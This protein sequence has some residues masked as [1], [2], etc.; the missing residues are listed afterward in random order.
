[1][2]DISTPELE[3]RVAILEA[4]C[5]DKHYEM[6]REILSH[7]ASTIQSNVRELE[8][9]LNKVI[10]YHQFKNI[11]PSIESV[12]EIISSF[13]ASAGS[14]RNLTPKQLLET[15]AAYFDLSVPDLLGKCR[16]KRL[17]FPRQ[18]IMYLMRE[19]M[20]SSYPAIGKMIGGRDH[21]TAIHAYNKIAADLQ[22]DEKIKHDI[23]MIKQRLYSM[24]S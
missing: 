1:M 6:N 8:G 5:K 2:V 23:D 7:V 19:E 16:E 3:T 4:K 11:K 15:V 10:A 12:R 9:A 22:G 21:T 14:K 18:I 24:V 17:S 13:N 20:N